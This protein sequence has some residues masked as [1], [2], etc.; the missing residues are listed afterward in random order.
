[1]KNKSKYE[2][3]GGQKR[4]ILICFDLGLQQAPSRGNGGALQLA[5]GS[6]NSWTSLDLSP[7]RLEFLLESSQ[8]RKQIKIRAF[9]EPETL[10][11]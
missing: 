4:C 10:Y 3:F 11:F 1:M 7:R 9:R 6:Y 5:Q 8:N 2:R